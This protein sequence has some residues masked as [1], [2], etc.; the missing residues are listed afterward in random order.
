MMPG[1]T[2]DYE[3]PEGTARAAVPVFE[4]FG[5]RTFPESSWV[6]F[7]DK[8]KEYVKQIPHEELD[9]MQTEAWENGKLGW[10]ELTKKQQQDLLQRYPELAE[11]YDSAQADS[12]LRDSGVWKAYTERTD[13][14]RAVY[15]ER[16]DELTQRL[17]NGEID[18]R[19]YRELCSEAGQN[20][21]AIIEAMEREPAYAE[22]Y[23]YFDE[24]EA[25]GS[26]YEFRWDLA[27]GE[28]NSEIRFADDMQLPN[29]DYDWDERD[30]R[31]AG[32]VEKWGEDLYQ[33]ILNYISTTK[34]EKGL[35]PLW[36][37][38]SQ[39]SEKLS[40]EYW[41]LPYKPITEMTQEDFEQGNIPS[42]YYNAWKTYQNMPEIDKEGFLALN[43][44]LARDWRAEYRKS[45]PEA[46]AMLALWGY[47]GKLQS[48][49]AYNLVKQWSQ[50]LG[51]PLSQ[52]GLGLPPQN[53]IQDYFDYNNLGVSGN[54]AEAKL[55]RI[56]HPEFQEWAAE[57]WG[58]KEITD[59]AEALRLKVQL[60]T[61]T[62]GTPE[63]IETDS[64][65]KAYDKGVGDEYIDLYIEY[66]KL[67]T[68]GYDQE[69]FLMENKDYYDDVWLGVLGNQPKDFSKIPT[70]E[71]E[72]LLD[73][74]DG[75]VT[76][77][78]R[79]AARCQDAALDAALVKLRGLTPAYGTDRCM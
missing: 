69:R 22:I 77:S 21:G 33:E 29:G 20:Y 79:L 71:E 58:W 7:Y 34:E 48:M 68:A 75:L 35:N 60:K 32:F 26:K 62:P 10:G 27:Y 67:P 55:W 52:M 9:P 57:N 53:L 3:I 1:A 76:G 30:R 4:I 49:E 41:N 15:Y 8:V 12:K 23:Q 66:Y 65:I 11:L 78:P 47:G 5:W 43:P 74:Y 73:Y 54:S 46:D 70:V 28:Y 64:R 63:Y 37:R 51:I 45:H 19:T 36:V 31:I 14:E 42:Q 38:R 17:L 44:D 13:E 59:N 61:L 39:D 18:T 56:E 40:R 25:E 24:K 6:K 2:R 16:I 50:E 72:K